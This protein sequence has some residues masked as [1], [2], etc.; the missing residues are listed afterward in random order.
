[1]QMK[2]EQPN[3]E[4]SSRRKFVQ[5]SSATVAVAGLAGCLG[6][7]ERSAGSADGV[8]TIDIAWQPAGLLIGSFN[9]LAGI[10]YVQEN[11]AENYG[12]V[13]DLNLTGV[14]GTNEIVAATAAGEVDGGY[15]PPTALA[16][17]VAAG[18]L[19]SDDVSLVWPECM[20]GPNSGHSDNFA[21]AADS[22]ITDWDDIPG[23]TFAIN[24]F[25][26]GSDIS[27]R[28]GMQDN[29]IDPENDVDMVQVPFSDQVAALESGRID[30]G[31]FL[32]PFYEEA[33]E[34]VG[35]LNFLYDFSYPFGDLNTFN[36][37][38][39]NEL[40]DEH[41]DAVRALAE[42]V[43]EAA[44]FERGIEGYDHDTAIE[45]M[46]E[47]AGVSTDIGSRLFGE[48]ADED[49]PSP[50]GRNIGYF[51]PLNKRQRPEDINPAVDAMFEAGQLDEEVDYTDFLN[52]DFYPDEVD[53]LPE[54]YQ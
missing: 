16:P 48:V 4:T 29:G 5:M 44:K 38:L 23:T 11:V 54:P 18:R 36:F 50:E 40:L 13:Y 53:E 17:A 1:M 15:C 9:K 43:I 24:T 45:V 3:K 8:T 28:I 22:G 41:P 32:Q 47:A 20:F 30:I 10:E 35:G 14:E 31:T 51:T 42:D 49:Y 19:T 39:S 12:E 7:D 34:A 6:S 46:S 21:A 26:S 52:N 27:A 25:G 2:S 33:R 37:M